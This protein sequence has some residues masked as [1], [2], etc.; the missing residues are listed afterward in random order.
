MLLLI[1]KQIKK[2]NVL[3]LE[4]SKEVLTIYP[5]LEVLSLIHKTYPPSNVDLSP[6]MINLERPLLPYKF[7]TSHRV[8]VGFWRLLVMPFGCCFVLRDPL[9]IYG[10][11]L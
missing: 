1:K 6:R 2:L 10:L 7:T 11:E 5:T 8:W 9:S 3:F 4:A